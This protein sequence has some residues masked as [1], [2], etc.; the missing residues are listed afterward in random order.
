MR[1]GTQ[2][3]DCRAMYSAEVFPTMNDRL[4]TEGFRKHGIVLWKL[5]L[6]PE[7]EEILIVSWSDRAKKEE[8]AS[9]TD[10]ALSRT[11]S[12]FRSAT[13]PWQRILTE[14]FIKILNLV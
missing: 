14:I 10:N 1:T 5:C 2:L 11:I 7:F 9:A 8:W 13:K 4:G 3:P 6:S 12:F